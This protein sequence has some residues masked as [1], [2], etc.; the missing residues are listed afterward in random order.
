MVPNGVAQLVD[1]PV[2]LR[3]D[4]NKTQLFTSVHVYDVASPA[5]NLVNLS[6]PNTVFQSSKS[7]VSLKQNVATIG[8][9]GAV[10]TRVI[11]VGIILGVKDTTGVV[12]TVGV[13]VV[14]NL[15]V[16]T[17]GNGVVDTVGVS[18]FNISVVL[19]CVTPVFKKLLKPVRVYGVNHEA[20][21]WANEVTVGV[22]V[23]VRVRA[24]VRVEVV[25]NGLIY[26]SHLIE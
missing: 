8:N 17:V 21:G 5:R 1:K 22:I 10:G 12:D 2:E 4:A 14:D 24:D 3:L 15:V 18:Q 9:G 20:A 11:F 26:L 23:G 16:L 7:C 19:T 6:N 25:G 13:V